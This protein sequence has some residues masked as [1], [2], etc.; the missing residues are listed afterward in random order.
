MKEKQFKSIL[1]TIHTSLSEDALH[2]LFT[3][4]NDIASSI[5]IDRIL[6]S[7]T[8]HINDVDTCSI[9]RYNNIM[10]LHIADMTLHE[11]SFIA[12]ACKET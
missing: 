6:I 9:N 7:N 8:K 12:C 10:Q 11:L 1:L 4:L 2:K 5:D 3:A